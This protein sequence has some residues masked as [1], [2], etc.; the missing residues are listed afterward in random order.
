MD[1][2]EDLGDDQEAYLEDFVEEEYLV[3]E[4]EEETVID[5]ALD[6]D[7]FSPDPILDQEPGASFAILENSVPSSVPSNAKKVNLSFT[8]YNF[9]AL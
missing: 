3:D 9:D 1:H 2:E 6:Y 5:G 7:A 4:I 8:Y